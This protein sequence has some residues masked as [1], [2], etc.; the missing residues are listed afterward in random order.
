M[1]TVQVK[2]KI[3][4]IEDDKKLAGAL[5]EGLASEGYDVNSASTAEEGFFLIH[6]EHPDLL[7]LDLSLPYRNGLEILRQVRR[8][9]LDVRVVVLTS[10]NTVGDRV[11]GLQSGADDYL[12]KPFSFPELSARV[13]ALLRRIV[14]PTTSDTL[15]IDDLVLNTRIRTASRGQVE[16][17][18]TG[19]EFDLLLYLA[20]NRGRTVS[21][22]MLAKDVWKESSRYTP[23][24]NVIDVQVA[25]LR[26]K[27]DDSFPIKLLHTVRGMG[28]ILRDPEA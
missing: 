3:L 15:K 10:H 24:D 5:A 2:S 23:L 20:E 12:G 17:D 27:I 22:E 9:G 13:Q 28:F 11:E 16:I 18:L 7:I 4:I 14:A 6:S 25:R 8:E 21:R 1:S 19:R 26:R